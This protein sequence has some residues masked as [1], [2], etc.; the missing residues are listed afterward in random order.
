M[1]E[2]DLIVRNGMIYDGDGGAPFKG[3]VAVNDDTIMAVGDLGE[4]HGKIEV[5]AEGQAVAPGFINMLSWSV[6][7]LIEDGL[8]QSEIRQGVTLEVMGEGSSMG[9][10]NEQMKRDGPG[11]FL[12]QG[13]IQYDVEW[14]T[15]GEYLEYLARRGVSCNVASFVGTSTLRIHVMGYD[16]R[17]ADWEKDVIPMRDLVR[18]AMEEG[19][20]GLSS[21]LIYPPASYADTNELIYLAE[22][23][24][25]Y[26]GLYISHIRNEGSAILEALNEFH[27]IVARADVRGEIYHLKLAG[28]SNWDKLD[29]VI[30]FI[31]SCRKD[32]GLQITAD[33]YPYPYSGTGLASCLPPWVHDGGHTAMIDR[34]KDPA[35]R[36][37]IRREMNQPSLEWENMYLENGP[38]RILLAGFKQDTMKPLT[39]RYLAEIAMERG[40]LPE[41]TLMDLIIEDDSR[42]F[43]VYFSMSEDNVKRIMALPWVSFCSD[44]ESQAPEGV[45]LKSNP[46]PRAYGAF[47]RILGKYARD[48]GVMPLEDAIH[49]LTA[50]PAANLKI[51][52]RGSLKAGYFADMVV[53]DPAQ[54]HDHATP[55][56]PHQY[57][58]GM[59]H[60]FVNGV[61]VLK[62]GEHTGAKPGRVVRGPGYGKKPFRHEYPEKLHPLLEI[63]DN[64]NRNYTEFEI[65][66]AYIPDLIR[67]ATDA[68]LHL[69]EEDR[70]EYYA[71][72]HA[73]RRLGQLRTVEAAQP[74]TQIFSYYRL[75][76]VT[77][78]PEVYKMIGTPAIPAL[79]SYLEQSWHDAMSQ[80][81]A[82]ACLRTIATSADALM[83]A[84]CEGI[85][86]EKLKVYETNNPVV[87]SSLVLALITLE[88][89]NAAPVIIEAYQSGRVVEEMT[90]SFQDI[91]K[92]LGLRRLTDDE[93]RSMMGED[94]TPGGGAKKKP[95]HKPGLKPKKSKK[96]KRR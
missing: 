39:G 96:K 68:R 15:L 79:K 29:K 75:D 11:T 77:E 33:M 31:E 94:D 43:T 52:R 91:Q 35:T 72:V 82:V 47:A 56:R 55:E 16:D 80:M 60:V 44:A 66:R 78:L 20:V 81:Q 74:L 12:Q 63:G 69:W 67:M 70:P 23:V 13:D 27:D 22:I 36:E 30:D 83:Y 76:A 73:W 6:E 58:T 89:E 71:P 37:R 88:S 64:Y 8:S 48:E 62:D 51:D 40:T 49:R 50:L 53:F 41:D 90:G 34:L 46:H 17:P 84:V 54:V 86:I 38:E 21:A 59:T 18:Q 45:F 87:N 24:S 7:S 1:L 61:Q 4:A 65:G 57:A 2:Y 19:A 95:K 5:N 85:L 14:A 93:R 32:D 25:A 3:D 92:R 28:Q 10:L 9:P 26:D 42:I